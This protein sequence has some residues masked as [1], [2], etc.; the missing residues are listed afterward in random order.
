MSKITAIKS[1]RPATL[2]KRYGFDQFGVMKKSVVANVSVGKAMALNIDDAKGLLK[3][4]MRAC[5][6]SDFALMSGSFVGAKENVTVQ[7]VTENELAKLLK[8][9][10][11]EVPGGVKEVGGEIY[12]ARLKRG[13]EPSAWILIDADDPPGIPPEWAAMSLQKRLEFLEEIVPGISS[14]SRVEYRSSSARVVKNDQEPRGA[15]HAWI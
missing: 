12:A 1:S 7:L 4:L 13:I 9:S 2:G 6:K 11:K 10:L 3:V 5:E 8:C 14:C 15:T